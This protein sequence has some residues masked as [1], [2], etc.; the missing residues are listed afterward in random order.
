MV[1]N[2]VQGYSLEEEKLDN[3][4]ALM[5]S[6]M[7]I[8]PGVMSGFV[9][10]TIVFLPIHAV[11]ALA[12]AG[13]LIGYIIAYNT[14][15]ESQS[16]VDQALL[17]VASAFSIFIGAVLGFSFGAIFLFKFLPGI[18]PNI[19]T[20]L[21]LTIGMVLG[22]KLLPEK[23]TANICVQL[24]IAF[25][26][27]LFTGMTGFI[28]LNSFPGWLSFYGWAS[29]LGLGF[30]GGL[31][32]GGV[33]ANNMGDSS[34]PNKNLYAKKAIVN[35][36]LPSIILGL[37]IAVI[38]SVVLEISSNYL[39]LGIGFTIA[40]C[41]MAGAYK[42]VKYFE[43]QDDA[44]SK[45]VAHNILLFTASL[46]PFTFAGSLISGG[47]Y[48]LLNIYTDGLFFAIVSGYCAGALSSV[49]YFCK[50]TYNTMTKDFET[51]RDY[52][53]ELVKP[54]DDGFNEKNEENRGLES[55][56][57]LH[58]NNQQ[59]DNIEPSDSNSTVFSYKN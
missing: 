59:G 1:N 55:V 45:E 26:I 46:F 56:L 14:I 36:T 39:M 5:S 54:F 24:S 53:L 4:A 50:Q 10:G 16:K 21:G 13:G 9:F 12:Y 33:I 58:S 31:L 51:P 29:G 25:E 34:D 18:W 17:S 49:L 19:E 41:L 3:I 57:Y 11:T 47:I 38:S 42:A 40:S 23:V 15:L 30:L 27:M 44:Y 8:L 2:K 35:A 43:D 28:L 20:F 32:I 22:P 7:L 6:S 37:S 48:S 52:S